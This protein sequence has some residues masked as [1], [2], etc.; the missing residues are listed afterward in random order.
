MK[1]TKKKK[2]KNFI[3]LFYDFSFNV[4]LIYWFDN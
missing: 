3:N 2:N 1:K 4:F